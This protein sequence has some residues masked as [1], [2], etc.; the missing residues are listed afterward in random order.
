MQV[1]YASLLEQTLRIGNHSVCKLW[2]DLRFITSFTTFQR[3][4]LLYTNLLYLIQHE[5][6]IHNL[7]NLLTN[8][9]CNQ[10]WKTILLRILSSRS[11][12]KSCPN[13][14]RFVQ[15]NNNVCYILKVIFLQLLPN[16][17]RVGIF[18]N[19]FIPQTCRISFSRAFHIQNIS[20]IV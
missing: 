14:F 13:I 12:Y 6:D 11:F 4:K 18:D 3:C 9:N 15:S 16:T 10:S 7:L 1:I 5:V 2:A 20:R 8:S 17:V 19:Q